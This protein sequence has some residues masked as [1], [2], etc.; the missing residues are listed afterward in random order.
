VIKKQI[1]TEGVLLWW[2]SHEVP[3]VALKDGL[4]QAQSTELLPL[5]DP[6]ACLK[7]VCD[8]LVTATDMKVRGQPIDYRQLRKDVVG[9]QAVREIKGDKQNQYDFLFSMIA[10]G[11]DLDSLSIR[12]A[13]VD[14]DTAPQ[15]ASKM[16][17][18]EKQAK[19]LWVAYK[20]WTPA[21]DLTDAMRRLVYKVK[22][23]M[24]KESGGLYFI[25]EEAAEMFEQV[26]SVIEASDTEAQFTIG[27]TDLTM[28]KRM[29]KK[30]MQA[31]ETEILAETGK[32]QDE[33]ATLADNSKKMRRNGIERRLKDISDWTAK[34]EYYEELMGVAM[35]KLRDA[36]GQAQYAIGVHGLEALGASE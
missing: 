3:R 10:Y 7:K 22:G 9:V 24:L 17:D 34:V 12:F 19:D 16:A 1:S 36:I 4:M 2:D 29:F 20:D 28:N 15:I 25:P 32:F 35:P 27:V 11:N 31:L 8:E 14:P 23:V 13:K 6:I 21:K 18:L 5:F 33:I 30:V 26:A